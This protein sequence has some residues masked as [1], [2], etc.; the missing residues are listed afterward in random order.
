M[1]AEEIKIHCG[2]GLGWY[3]P[4]RNFMLD[5][6]ESRI[7]G[8]QRGKSFQVWGTEVGFSKAC[9]D[10]W[11]RKGHDEKDLHLASGC[12]MYQ[13]M[14]SWSTG[15]HGNWLELNRWGSREKD[16]DICREGQVLGMLHRKNL[17]ASKADWILG[18][19]AKAMPVSSWGW[20]ACV[21]GRIMVPCWHKWRIRKRSR[22]DKTLRGCAWL[23]GKPG[24]E[25]S[26]ESQE[27]TVSWEQREDNVSG[28]QGEQRNQKIRGLSLILYQRRTNYWPLS[29]LRKVA[30]VDARWQRPR[31]GRRFCI[32][33]EIARQDPSFSYFHW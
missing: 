19:N 17:I 25:R 29:N 1:I 20:G 27:P 9:T 8:L 15:S 11:T 7:F 3:H 10:P 13:R 24:K 2:R 6:G 32:I 18:S 22:P 5:L 4:R 14:T 30:G 33:G 12:R 28:R 16:M 21:S 23:G 26:E 31:K